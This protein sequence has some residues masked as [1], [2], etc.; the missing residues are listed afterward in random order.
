MLKFY[1]EEAGR[2]LAELKSTPDGLT[3][4][5]AARRLAEKGPNKL[6]EGKKV[7]TLQRFLQQLSDPMII[8]LLVAAAVS[9][10]T[11]AYSGESFADVFIIL[12]V[13]L[14]NAVLGVYQESKAEKAIE[15]LQEMTAATSKVIRGGKQVSLKSEEL[16]PGDV[17]VLEAGD[18]VPADGRIL[19]SASLKIE[20][21]ALTGESVPVNKVVSALG[22]DDGKDVPLGDRKNMAYM[23]ST[24]VY[25]RGRV[26]I[27]G[28]GMDTEMGKIAGALAQA[29][30]GQTPL[31]KKLAR[32]RHLRIH[33]RLQPYQGGRFPPRRHHQYV[34]GS[35]QSCRRGHP[36]GPCH[37]RYHRTLHR[38]NEHV[39]AQCRHPPPY[40]CGDA[41]LRTGHLL[42][43]NRYA[44][45]EQDDGCGARG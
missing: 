25:G 29:E 42:G 4:A 35:G 7:T 22:L 15:A 33:L 12:I 34:H 23:G 8:I 44:D 1:C 24:V 30:E 39:Q 20:E 17:V 28:T 9:G 45:A 10:V 3:D 32:A 37:R 11:A 41:G 27:T 43:Q 31:Q 6:A 40:G 16:V 14:I 13:V 5:E 18:A 26:L 38:R 36:R 2:A 21:A 19:E